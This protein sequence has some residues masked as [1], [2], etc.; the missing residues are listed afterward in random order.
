M[1]LRTIFGIGLVFILG[2]IAGVLITSNF[3]SANN[4][5]NN[6]TWV[7][8]PQNQLQQFNPFETVQSRENPKDR[9]PEKAI[10]VYKDRIILDIS[11]AQWATFT[12][13]H[14]MEPVIFKGA[15]AIE[16]TPKSEEDIKVGDIVSYKSVYAEGNIIHRVIYKGQD[17]QGVYFVMKGD[18]L[19]SSD[20]GR[21]RFSQMQ[22]VVI[23][24][25]Y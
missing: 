18:N 5:I 23:G 12:D 3:A 8:T 16:V 17:E 1:K 15:N 19:P 6:N 11:N 7:D 2:I 10:E 21:V 13:T 14:S 9:V 22:R 20:P 4:E 24:L 25:I